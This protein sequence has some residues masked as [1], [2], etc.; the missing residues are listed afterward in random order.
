MSNEANIEEKLKLQYMVIIAGR[1]LK[2]RLLT[3]MSEKKCHVINIIFGR[4]AVDADFL[5]DAL[6]LAAEE[7]KIL[8]T[9]L[10][11]NNKADEVFKMLTDD[12]DFDKPNTG[13][14][15]VVPVENLL[16]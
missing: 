2:D 11:L 8:V 3:A 14:A 7:N 13:I 16:Y 6:G 12:F 9:C 15:F 4:G 1:N 10:L 5:M